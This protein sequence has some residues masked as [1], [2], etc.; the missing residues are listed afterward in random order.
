[1]THPLSV[2]YSIGCRLG[3]KTSSEGVAGI[4]PIL[5]FDVIVPLDDKSDGGRTHPIITN[6]AVLVDGSKQRSRN[7]L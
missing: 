6:M 2:R 3:A 1:M 5:T 7:D 4:I